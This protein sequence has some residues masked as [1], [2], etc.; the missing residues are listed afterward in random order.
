VDTG[1]LAILRRRLSDADKA[2]LLK[3]LPYAPGWV[4]DI[5][6]HLAG[7]ESE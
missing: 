3:D 4:A 2:Q 7:R 6:R 1:V 5:M